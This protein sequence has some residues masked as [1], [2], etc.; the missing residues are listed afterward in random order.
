MGIAW[1]LQSDAQTMLTNLACDYPELVLEHIG[2]LALNSAVKH[3]A[4]IESWPGLV[5]A[6]PFEI[7]KQ[8]VETN[9]L[10]AAKFIAQNCQSPFPTPDNPTAVPELTAWV[11][12]IFENDD[13]VFRAFL[14]G[15]HTHETFFGPVSNVFADVAE[16]MKPYLRHPLRRIREWARYEI[17]HAQQMSALDFHD[18]EFGRE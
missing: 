12:S 15:R 9:G 10:D 16:R 4:I 13:E 3:S 8:W 7:S 14:L 17:R 18:D 11:L 5:S 1:T 6:I 2:V